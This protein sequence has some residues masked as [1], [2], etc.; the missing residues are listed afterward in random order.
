[1]GGVCW[2]LFIALFRMGNEGENFL[3]R[4]L[5]ARA[6]PGAGGAGYSITFA[7]DDFIIGKRERFE[8]VVKWAVGWGWG[9]TTMK[10]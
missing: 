9:W 4:R 6:R 8:D 10:I 5:R 7:R 1:M 3:S 2:G